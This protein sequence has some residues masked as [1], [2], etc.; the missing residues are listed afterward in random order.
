VLFVNDHLGFADGVIHG[1]AR[2][3]LNVLPRFDPS[4]VAPS[5]CILRDW[6]P[7][8]EHLEKA[9]I[10]P[11]FLNRKKWDPRVVL[12][13]VRMI[14]SLDINVIHLLGMKG[15]LLGR[16]AARITGTPCLIHLR[17]M[18]PI[19]STIRFMQQRL[20]AWTDLALAVSNPVRS[21][22][23]EQLGM[24]ANRVKVLHNPIDMAEFDRLTI[25]D[26]EQARQEFGIPMDAQVVGIVARLSEEKGHKLLIQ[27][28][29]DLLKN[30]PKAILLV[31]GDGPT[32]S[33]CELLAKNLNLEHAIR[34]VGY[35]KDIPRMVAAMDVAVMASVREGFPNAALEAMA[36]GKPVVAF[37]VGG[38]PEIVI[39]GV[40]GVLVEPNSSKG[41]VDML[42]RVLSDPDLRKKQSEAGKQH[43]QHFNM[44]QHLNS[45]ENIYAGLARPSGE[46]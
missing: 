21:F 8:A 10:P 9:G 46:N 33:E 43:V 29:P 45:L 14:R 5:L 12:D 22:T 39:H 1:P 34:F 31:V 37:S 23:I 41:L 42:G 17:D 24:P 2:Y 16:I 7:F 13:L 15:C 35:R 20:A 19:G 25:T 32:R 28:L 36:A 11:I 26:R 44:E 30:C 3:F 6:H 27:S 18:N 4:T 38:L 40:T